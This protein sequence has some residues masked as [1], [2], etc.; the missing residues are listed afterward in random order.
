MIKASFLIV[1]Y[2]TGAHE[3]VLVGQAFIRIAVQGELSN[4]SRFVNSC[5]ECIE[6]ETFVYVAY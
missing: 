4:M 3:Y 5:N 6:A 2:S 1:D